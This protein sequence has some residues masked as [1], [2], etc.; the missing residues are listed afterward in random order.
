MTRKYI[1]FLSV[2]ATLLCC[3]EGFAQKN[4]MGYWAPVFHEDFEERVPGPSIGD[5]A[6]LPINE[7]ARLRA[8]SWDASLL[9]L[10][11][12]QCKPHPSTYGFRGVGTLRIWEQ[13][14]PESQALVA[15]HTHIA[16][17]AQHR[18][19]W[20][21]GRDRPPPHAAHTW[22]GFSTGHWEGDVLVAETSHLKAGWMRRNGLPLSDRATM[23]DRFIRHGD[24]M[25]HVMIIEDPVYLTEPLVKTNG[26]L[27]QPNGT[28]DPY[29]CD[30]VVE[31]EYPEGYV[32]HY[33]PGE[34]PFL[35]EFAEEHDLPWEATLG[36]SHTALPEYAEELE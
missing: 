7:A 31:V 14:D 22:Q 19:I 16:W 32:P 8:Q 15:I 12:H 11:E 13:R 24:V 4:L 34:N 36:G 6:G 27:L 30:A 10:P 20:M 9:S 23:T 2:I 5:Y 29:P 35:R 28:M 3:A 26:F 18:T 25:T 1:A 17:Q 33:L 21:D